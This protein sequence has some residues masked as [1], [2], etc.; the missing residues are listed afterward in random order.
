MEAGELSEQE[1]KKRKPHFMLLPGYL[2]YLCSLFIDNDVSAL[3]HNVKAV[4]LAA[5]CICLLAGIFLTFSKR[6]GD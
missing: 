1:V 3:M 6:G 5:A 2:L 4:M